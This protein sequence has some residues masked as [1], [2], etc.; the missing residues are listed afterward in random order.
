MKITIIAVGKLKRSCFKEEINH[1]L[2]QLTT[3]VEIIEINDEPTK[4]GLIKEGMKIL[5]KIPANSYIIGLAIAGNKIDS[6]MFSEKLENLILSEKR[7]ITFIIGGSYG[8]AD[9]VLKQANELISFSDFTF[10]HNLM[11]LIL[12]EQLYRAFKIIEKHPYH[13]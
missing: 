6:L 12:V 9:E 4:S 5:A 11:R 3:P 8:L 10:P 1:Y 7:P 13:K 2:K